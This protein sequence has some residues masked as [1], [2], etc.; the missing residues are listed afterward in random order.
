MLWGHQTNGTWRNPAKPAGEPRLATASRRAEHARRTCRCKSRSRTQSNQMQTQ[1][2]QNRSQMLAPK[3]IKASQ[4][5]PTQ[6][7]SQSIPKPTNKT[8]PTPD[9]AQ[10]NNPTQTTAANQIQIHQTKLNHGEPSLP[11]TKSSPNGRAKPNQGEP[12]RA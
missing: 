11:Q 3:H 9:Q 1:T 2:Y 6:K 8:K 10:T 7:S 4:A 5:K 12:S